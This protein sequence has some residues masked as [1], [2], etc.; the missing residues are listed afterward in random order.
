MGD[1]GGL[2]GDGS[3]S[4]GDQVHSRDAAGGNVDV[5]PVVANFDF[6]E[7]GSL[8]VCSCRNAEVE[9]RLHFRQMFPR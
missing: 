4:C 3:F 7:A 5:I 9:G 2:S 1:D 6:I 8:R